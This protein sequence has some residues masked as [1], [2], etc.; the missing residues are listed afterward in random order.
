MNL[1]KHMRHV[2]AAGPKAHAS[3]A[4]TAL[5]TCTALWGPALVFPRAGNALTLF[6]EDIA[7]FNY[8][9]NGTLRGASFGIISAVLA[10]CGMGTATSDIHVLPWARAVHMTQTTPDA[11]LFSAA[12]TPQRETMFKW[13]GPVLPVTVGAVVRKDFSAAPRHFEDLAALRIATVRN[14]AGEQLLVERGL[15]LNALHSTS[16]P[17]EAVRM[18]STNRVDVIIFNIHTILHT[19]QQLGIDSSEYTVSLTIARFELFMAFNPDTDDALLARLQNTLDDMRCNNGVPG[20][21]EM[22]RI[23]APYAR[24]FPAGTGPQERNCPRKATPAH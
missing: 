3:L 8:M 22:A 10:R 14:S 6:T 16:N 23:V 13:V 4:A 5:L 7:P 15:A 19:M 2:L 24:F 18:L 20:S 17:E 21:S 1:F 9:E 12:R 11:L